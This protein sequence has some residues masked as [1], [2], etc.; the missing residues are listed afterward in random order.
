MK[1][2]E[3][4]YS[5]VEKRA[6][7][8]SLLARATKTLGNFAK[9]QAHGLTGAYA[10]EAAS[11]GLSP[12]AVQQGVTSLPGLARG[13]ASRPRETLHA[14]GQEALSGGAATG[15]GLGVGLPLA[16]AAP[17]LARGDESAKGGRSLR[18]KAVGLGAQV[19]GGA[20][21]AGVPV[22]PGALGG[23]A[24]ESIASRTLGRAG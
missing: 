15:L 6:G 24:I 8:S 21:T 14:V 1:A 16:L 7:S 13:L 23:A 12:K 18:Q 22:I 17:D 3:V 10:N 20:L 4:F 19:A 2:L 9:R 5:E 11:I